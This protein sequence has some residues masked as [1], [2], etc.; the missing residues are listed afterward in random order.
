MNVFD[1]EVHLITSSLKGNVTITEL[2]LRSNE[3]SDD[4]ARAI[5]SMLTAPSV[6]K[7]IDLR[8]NR[9]SRIG[10]RIIA[11]ALERSERVTRVHIQVGGRIEALSSRSSTESNSIQQMPSID[12]VC[13]IDIRDNSPPDDPLSEI[14]S[15]SDNPSN[16]STKLTRTRKIKNSQA[17]QVKLK[18]KENKKIRCHESRIKSNQ[19]E[20]RIFLIIFCNIILLAHF[21]TKH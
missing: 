7:S 5:A 14:R 11:E 18:K 1:E 8:G 17:N 13:V 12:V 6:L 21:F 10:L 16:S 3:I 9:I 4:G 15:F 20:V 2:N 19:N